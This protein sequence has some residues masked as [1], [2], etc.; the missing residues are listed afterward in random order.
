MLTVG[1]RLLIFLASLLSTRL[2]PEFSQY[3]VFVKPVVCLLVF[4]LRFSSSW[5][6]AQGPGSVR[7]VQRWIYKLLNKKTTF[8]A[9]RYMYLISQWLGASM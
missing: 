1:K 2:P 5:D 7:L 3:G 4:I 9:L 8:G 6:K